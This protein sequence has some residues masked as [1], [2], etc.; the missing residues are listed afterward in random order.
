MDSHL[1]VFFSL[2]G[3]GAETWVGLAALPAR[4]FGS[5][6]IFNCSWTILEN[7]EKGGIRSAVAVRVRGYFFLPFGAD[8]LRQLRGYWLHGV[9][10]VEAGKSGEISHLTFDIRA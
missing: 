3:L 2:R 4:T 1:S 8:K 5:F 7:L 10:I 6:F 9:R